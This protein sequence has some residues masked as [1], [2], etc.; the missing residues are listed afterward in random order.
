MRYFLFVCET[1][2]A[3]EMQFFCKKVLIY[4]KICGILI[5]VMNVAVNIRGIVHNIGT[6]I[7]C[8][9]FS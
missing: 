8:C 2:Y 4:E 5:C 6:C 1:V 7:D 3:L 9:V